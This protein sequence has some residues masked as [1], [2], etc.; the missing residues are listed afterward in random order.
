MTPCLVKVL[1]LKLDIY[2]VQYEMGF[3]TIAFVT[4]NMMNADTTQLALTLG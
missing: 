2:V 3:L 4:K 1:K